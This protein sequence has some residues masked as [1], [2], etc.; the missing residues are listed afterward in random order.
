M[1][2]VR[3]EADP[4]SPAG[5]DGD[6][7]RAGARVD[8]HGEAESGWGWGVGSPVSEVQNGLDGV[9][10]TCRDVTFKP[11]QQGQK[12]VDS[13]TLALS[14]KG[15]ESEVPPVP[16]PS[17]APPQGLSHAHNPIPRPV[18]PLLVGLQ[19]SVHNLIAHLVQNGPPVRAANK[20]L[21][22]RQGPKRDINS[23]APA[24]CQPQA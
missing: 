10:T 9:T 23:Q 1:G 5:R 7:V 21:I 17:P 22:L 20:E 3:R 6:R 4:R 2:D 13:E 14:G 11:R 18:P 16:L 24:P 19:D 12:H 8:G 15:A